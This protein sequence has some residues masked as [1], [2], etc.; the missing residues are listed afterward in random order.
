MLPSIDLSHC[1]GPRPSAQKENG[2]GQ[3]GKVHSQQLAGY[4]L[5][6]ESYLLKVSVSLVVL[7]CRMEGNSEGEVR[8]RR[9]GRWSRERLTALQHSAWRI[10]QQVQL[11]FCKC[12]LSALYFT[13]MVRGRD[14]EHIEQ[15][16]IF[17]DSSRDTLWLQLSP[18]SENYPSSVTS[19]WLPLNTPTGSEACSFSLCLLSEAQNLQ[20]HHSLFELESDISV[21]RHNE[22]TEHLHPVPIWITRHARGVS[23]GLPALTQ[24]TGGKVLRRICVFFF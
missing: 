24:L 23:Y 10:L 15:P 1:S 16:H 5:T 6:Y 17:T 7:V 12:L 2:L 8:R 11:L 20:E 21:A 13:L 4:L 14:G 18:P 3:R 19:P 22:W 9:Q